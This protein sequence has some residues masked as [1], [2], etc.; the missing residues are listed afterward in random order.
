MIDVILLG[1]IIFLFFRLTSLEDEITFLN[2]RQADL[3][4]RIC[5]AEA[6]LSRA[7]KKLR[8]LN[9]FLKEK[10]SNEKLSQR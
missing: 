1:F 9:F 2:K 5:D 7:E 4:K 6:D 3:A 8:N 10:N